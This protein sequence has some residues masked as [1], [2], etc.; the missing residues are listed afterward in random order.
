DDAR[1]YDSEVLVEAWV[2]GP[3][4]T[5]SVVGEQVLPAI[6]LKTPNQ[7]YDYE[8]KYQSNS[9]EYLCP[10]G[11]SDEDESELR[12]LSLRAF[13]VVGCQGWGR[14]DVMRDEQGRWQLLEVNTVPGMTDH[15]LVPMAAR[16]AGDEFPILVA[17]ILLDAVDRFPPRKGGKRRG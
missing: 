3:E 6:R 2:N 13:K 5:V 1:Q 8:A 10:A 9:T 15:S 4:Y 17:R 14:V 7:F 16:A 11:L 12:A